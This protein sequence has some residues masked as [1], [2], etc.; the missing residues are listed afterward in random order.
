M[1]ATK[2]ESAHA[3][4]SMMR[5]LQ[6][7]GVLAAAIAMLVCINARAAEEAFDACNLFTAAD[8]EAALGT[9]AAP[10]P[11]N[12]KAK[13][14]R[15]VLTCTYNGFKDNKAVAATAQYRFSRT[16]AEAQRAFDDARLQFQTKPMYISGAEAFWSKTGQ[17]N[18]RKGRTWMVL[19]VG[20]QKVNERDIEQAKKL[21]EILVKKL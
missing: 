12:P 8:A 1:A 5:K 18:L 19:S 14:P 7:L 6:A 21:A 16:E 9:A 13:R 2:N 3:R 4:R 15:V 17:L 10:E 11:V 20:P